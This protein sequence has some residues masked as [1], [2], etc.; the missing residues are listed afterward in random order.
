MNE[1]RK[2]YVR[3]ICRELAGHMERIEWLSTENPKWSCGTPVDRYSKRDMLKYSH[4][5]VPY[6][7]KY[8]NE[9]RD[10]RNIK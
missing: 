7:N 4:E 8:I 10:P 2:H 3:K 5:L 6:I 1:A 9:L